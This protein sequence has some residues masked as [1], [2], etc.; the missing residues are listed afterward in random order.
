MGRMPA[1]PWELESEAMSNGKLLPCPFCGANPQ[2]GLGKLQHDQ[3]H[4][5]PYQYHQVFCQNPGY[6]FNGSHARVE[7]QDKAAAF[8]R[9]NLR[10][11]I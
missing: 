9:W 4:G 7:A 2:Y 11:S 8:A 6:G 10:V 1:L 5:E 3:L